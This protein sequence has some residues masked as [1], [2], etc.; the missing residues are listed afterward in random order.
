MQF[1]LAI[2]WLAS[3]IEM[4]LSQIWALPEREY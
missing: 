3:S 1:S 4:E 2:Y